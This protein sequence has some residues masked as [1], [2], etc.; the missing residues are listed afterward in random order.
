MLRYCQK[1][2]NAK[3]GNK[4]PTLSLSLAENV[5]KVNLLKLE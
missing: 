2:Q 3:L 4:K 1:S 5:T